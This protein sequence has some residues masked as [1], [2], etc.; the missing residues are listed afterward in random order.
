MPRIQ[1][2]KPKSLLQGNRLDLGRRP[3]VNSFVGKRL[4]RLPR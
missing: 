4:A 1:L 2:K 3:Q